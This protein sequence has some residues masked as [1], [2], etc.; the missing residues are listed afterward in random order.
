MATWSRVLG[1]ACEVGLIMG[2]FGVAGCGETSQGAD[3]GG[4]SDGF[5]GNPAGREPPPDILSEVP[6]EDY[7]PSEAAWSSL[8]TA[9]PALIGRVSASPSGHYLYAAGTWLDAGRLQ[10]RALRSRDHGETWCVLATPEPVVQTPP[11][12]V[13][14]AEPAKTEPPPAK[15]KDKINRA[16]TLD[17]FG[18]K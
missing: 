5:G 6:C 9:R 4:S 12:E 14:P 11:V 7:R 1:K 8:R 10:Q 2:V 16:D 13:P 18:K 3:V 15:K 17:P